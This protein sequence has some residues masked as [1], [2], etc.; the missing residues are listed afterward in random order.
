MWSFIFILAFLA[1]FGIFYTRQ[2]RVANLPAQFPEKWRAIL[3][4]NVS[5]YVQ[6]DVDER[7]RFEIAILRFLTRVRITGVQIEVDITDKLLVA[8]SAV[9]PVFGFQD[10]HYSFLNEVLLYPGSFDSDYQFGNKEEVIL[11]MVGSGTME[12]KMILSKP[13]LHRGFGNAEDKQNVGIH[14]FI[15]LLDKEDG[16]IDGI[17]AT[18]KDKAYAVPWL[19][20]IHKQTAQI[21][22]GK[23]DINAYGATNEK[24]FLA[25]AGEYFFERPALLQKNHPELYRLLSIAFHQDTAHLLSH[26]VP[27]KPE[28]QRN[29]PC[30]CG[31]GQKFKRCCMDKSS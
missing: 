16:V 23:S 2:K 12:G 3:L 9:I 29:D 4:N 17:P 22:K 26:P 13:A 10:W 6:L 19:N 28:L 15:H 11:G 27:E 24:E 31:S 8:S 30:P 5:F 21:M 20:L 25:V 7:K 1:A 18:L 14:E